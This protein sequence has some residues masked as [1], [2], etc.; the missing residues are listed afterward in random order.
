MSS[1]TVVGSPH[2]EKRSDTWLDA[3]DVRDVRERDAFEPVLSSVRRSGA[4]YVEVDSDGD[5]AIEVPYG[6]TR[7]GVPTG[8]LFMLFRA[9]VAYVDA[10]H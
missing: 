10:R 4:V 2:D 5:L 6:Y 1:T 7:T 3:R 8:A 9:H